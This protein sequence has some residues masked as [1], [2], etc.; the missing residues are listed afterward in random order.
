MRFFV[1]CPHYSTVSGGFQCGLTKNA[2]DAIKKRLRRLTET[3]TGILS[4]NPSLQGRKREKRKTDRQMDEADY[5]QAVR[6]R[7]PD[8]LAAASDSRR[9]HAVRAVLSAVRSRLDR[10]RACVC[11]AHHPHIAQYGVQAGVDCSDPDS[12]CVRR[13]GV[14]HFLRQPSLEGISQSH[15]E[16][17]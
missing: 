13:G 6:R 14:S 9:R 3:K 5:E 7:N 15:G 8:R 11:S 17:R 10:H 4:Y 2:S 16:N 12:P 1:C